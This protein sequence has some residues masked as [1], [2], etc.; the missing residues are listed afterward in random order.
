MV[1]RLRTPGKLSYPFTAVLEY[2]PAILQFWEQKQ[3]TSVD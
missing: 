1:S 3:L 2:N